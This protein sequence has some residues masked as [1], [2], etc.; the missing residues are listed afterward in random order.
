MER[1]RE[2]ILPIA[3]Q[4]IGYIEH[5]TSVSIMRRGGVGQA[6]NKGVFVEGEGSLRGHGE[7]VCVSLLVMGQSRCEKSNRRKA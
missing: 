1:N 5:G 4:F 3:V 2:S 6:A 7:V